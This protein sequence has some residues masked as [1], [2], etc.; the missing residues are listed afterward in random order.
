MDGSGLSSGVYIIRDV[1]IEM[2]NTRE[3]MDS[4]I[5]L[6]TVDHVIVGFYS[7]L[8]FTALKYA[9]LVSSWGWLFV[10]LNVWFFDVYAYTRKY[11]RR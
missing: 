11:A 9:L 1:M 6:S 8:I 5:K 4:K 10:V 2:E 7:L 3:D